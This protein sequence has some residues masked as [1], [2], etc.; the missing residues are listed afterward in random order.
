MSGSISPPS[1]SIGPDDDEARPTSAGR[2]DLLSLT[3]STS[4]LG[5]ISLLLS[6]AL[7]S[8]FPDPAAAGVFTPGGTLVDRDVGVQVGNP[9]ASPSRRVDN[10]NALFSQDYYFKFGAAA[11]W[12]S[13]DFPKTMPFVPV[14]QRYDALK[15]YGD[16]VRTA[17]R[18][19]SDLGTAIGNAGG[20]EGR[21]EAVGD[22]SSPSYSLRA[23]GLMANGMIATENTGTTNELLT[24]RWYINE[25]YLDLGDVRNSDTAEGALRSYGSLVKAFNSYLGMMN[26]VIIPKVGDKFDLL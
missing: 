8:S 3:A 26:R 7:L 15:K 20:R 9:D 16:R 22:V 12:A 23:M 4:S 1:E 6:P 19:I 17:S 24:A 11:P 21:A 18:S 5:L 13:D 25:A 14:Q 2:R 10:S